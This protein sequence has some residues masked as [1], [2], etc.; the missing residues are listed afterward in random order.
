MAI[1]LNELKKECAITASLRGQD[2]TQ[3]GIV[4]H[5]AGEVVELQESLSQHNKGIISAEIADCI[6][7]CL[8]LSEKY[9]IDIEKCILD[10]IKY[11]ASR[12]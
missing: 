2:M 11:N 4:K 8:T 12:A 9:D 6:I 7:C 3:T 10:K 5:L 1:C